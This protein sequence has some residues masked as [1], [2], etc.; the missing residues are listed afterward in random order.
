MKFKK[1]LC[2]LTAAV[3]TLPCMYIPSVN[4]LDSDTDYYEQ[5]EEEPIY[6]PDFPQDVLD[7]FYIDW[8]GLGC[9]RSVENIEYDMDSGHHKFE[10]DGGY[11]MYCN[12]TEPINLC[13]V[14]YWH[15]CNSFN[16]YLSKE[17]PLPEYADKMDLYLDMKV[18]LRIKEEGELKTGPM[19]EL[20]GGKDELFVIEKYTSAADFSDYQKIGSY[21][22]GEKSYDLYKK[23]TDTDD[24]APVRYCSVYTDGMV[25]DA[26]PEEP[27]APYE[28]TSDIGAH[29]AN[30]KKLAGTGTVLDKYGILTEGKNGIGNIYH[31]D[32]LIGSYFT[33]PKE[34]LDQGA[35][36][37]DPARYYRSMIKNLDGYR[38]SLQT[39]DTG[40]PINTLDDGRYEFTAHEN[41]SYII[42]LSNGKLIASVP[43]GIASGVS[44]GKEYDGTTPL[45]DHNYRYNYTYI[46]KDKIN[47]DVRVWMLDPYVQV[48]FT[49]ENPQSILNSNSY[50]GNID[51]DGEQY[52]VYADAV[53][54]YD[55]APLINKSY[56]CYKF[57]HKNSGDKESDNE[58][59]KMSVPVSALLEAAK[60]Y[61][62]ESGKLCRMGLAVNSFMSGYYVDITE[63]NIIDDPSLNPGS[64]LID[65]TMRYD[66]KLGDYYFS[67]TTDGYM[68]GYE[69]GLF[70]GASG[71][72][73]PSYF[74]A[75]K[76][77]EGS[78]VFSFDSRHNITA[79]YKIKNTYDD[80]CQIGYDLEGGSGE[81]YELIRIVEKSINYPYEENFTPYG[82]GNMSRIPQ[83]A[84]PEF[85]KTYTAGGHEYDL[86]REFCTYIGCFNTIYTETYVCIR[87]D[88]EEG[89]ML[90]GSIDFGEHLA[91][92]NKELKDS[93]QV[94]RVEL[95][96]INGKVSGTVDALRNDIDFCE[97]DASDVIKGDFNDDLRIDSMDVISARKALIS[98]Q[99]DENSTAPA[100][101]DLNKNGTFEI[102]DVVLLQSFV[103]GKISAFPEAE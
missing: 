47:V 91:Q 3:M 4:A 102:A 83:T 13:H 54:D 66:Q 38:Y 5:K 67:S 46:T 41:N 29:L 37:A 43:E 11:A 78:E 59:R 27:S 18:Y 61:G 96:V 60:I 68:Y 49:E 8:T 35:D 72:S 63:N 2:M 76:I 42:P 17:F 31:Q 71:V 20:N 86:Y 1:V 10:Y 80:M 77:K 58:V 57:I 97:R 6:I 24:K 45:L 32:E 21:T 89:E 103:L 33:L 36:G 73:I 53:N 15:E 62:V 92:I 93:I 9:N 87:K 101:M 95:M 51:L 34:K 69:N 56:K 99:S 7:E 52:M 82:Y 26:D 65:A 74:E 16:M 94:S 48:V 39:F 30:L 19:L 28:M 55:M 40:W 50:L 22:T 70:S 14:G 25:T 44:A 100:Y 64:I 85:I 90:E 12:Q 23:V 79:E 88:Q 75:G 81:N 98:K 84:E